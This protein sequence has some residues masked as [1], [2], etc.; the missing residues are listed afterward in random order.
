MMSAML[1]QLIR[2]APTIRGM[3]CVIDACATQKPLPITD[4]A[5]M[6]MDTS[7]V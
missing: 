1:M 5:S 6:D 4:K 3:F 7:S 2:L